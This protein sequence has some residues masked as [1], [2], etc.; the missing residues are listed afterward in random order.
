MK[1][2]IILH[3]LSTSSKFVPH[4]GRPDSGQALAYYVKRNNTLQTGRL[5]P[6]WGTS[7]FGLGLTNNRVRSTNL[8]HVRPTSSWFRQHVICVRLTL[9]AFGQCWLV[10]A[11]SVP[12]L[13]IFGLVSYM[14][15]LFSSCFSLV[16]ATHAQRSA[17][18]GLAWNTFGLLRS[19]S[20]SFR[21]F[22]SG[23]RTTC[24]LL[25]RPT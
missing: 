25:V 24:G 11:K 1:A 13:V 9:V 18:L 2:E 23:F 20:G 22:S 10:S 3:T 4:I 5:M 15:L 7:E 21:Q 6:T 12:R 19:R 8:G 14:V 17:K 16:S